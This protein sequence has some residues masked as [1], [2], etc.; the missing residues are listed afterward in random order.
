MTQWIQEKS[1]GTPSDMAAVG[2]GQDDASNTTG[3]RSRFYI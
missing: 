3:Y 2:I 1:I